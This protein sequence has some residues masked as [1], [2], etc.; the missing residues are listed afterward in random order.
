MFGADRFASTSR[1]FLLKSLTND[2]A[3][4]SASVVLPTPPFI[5]TNA[6]IFPIL[7]PDLDNYLGYIRF[8][9]HFESY[10]YSW[11]VYV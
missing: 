3:V 10:L 5:D 4:S 7:S 1:T 11:G 6:R 8:W 2:A 9:L